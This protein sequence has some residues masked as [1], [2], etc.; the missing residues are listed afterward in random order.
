MQLLRRFRKR[1]QLPALVA[2]SSALEAAIGAATF[3]KRESDDSG[4]RVAVICPALGGSFIYSRDES[5]RRIRK[6]F[7]ELSPGGVERA[8]RHLEDSARIFLRPVRQAERHRNSWVHGWAG[9]EER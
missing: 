1:P 4:H 2:F 8:V 3:L 9:L 7:P 6:F 5:E